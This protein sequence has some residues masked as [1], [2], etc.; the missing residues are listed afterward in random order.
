MERLILENR[1]DLAKVNSFVFQRE[2]FKTVEVSE[3]RYRKIENS[4]QVIQK[5]IADGVPVYGVT[6]GFGDSCDRYVD[7]T[8]AE[9]LQFNLIEYLSCGQG[10][11]L[12]IEAARAMFVIRLNSLSLGQSGVS[13]DL[14]KHMCLL[15]EKDIIPVVPREGSLGASGDLV[16]LAYLAQTIQGQGS[17]LFQGKTQD[18]AEVFK[19]L[20]IP[21]YKLKAKE[22]L[23]IVNGTATMAGLFLYNL[24]LAQKLVGLAE[25]A[26]AWQCLSLMG[27][28]EAFDRFIN[29]FAKTNPGQKFSANEISQLLDAENYR[30]LRGQD[31][32]AADGKTLGFVQ[33]RYSLRCV[34]Q[35]LGPIRENLEKCEEI[36]VHE[37][38]SITDNPVINFENQLEMGGNFYGGYL[39]QGMDYLK[40]N[41]AQ[42]ADLIDRQVMML[43]DDKSNR[44]LSANLVDIEN[45]PANEKFVHHGLKGIHQTVSAITSE[46][47]QKSIPSSIFSR[48]SESHNQDKVSLGMSAAVTCFEMLESLYKI[49][50]M[51]LVCLAQ[52]LDLRKIQLQGKSSLANYK[53]IRSHVSFVKADR[54]LGQA[55][56]NL[57]DELKQ[58]ALYK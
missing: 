31:I 34:P 1:L 56:Q 23:A 51:Q 25:L 11:V 3:E 9:R 22:G 15:L 2:K 8:T 37:I 27:K 43:V 32:Q 41:L 19:K 39:A 13:S 7:A 12:P 50:S 40:I 49:S 58:V 21:P 45:L 44:G 10:P 16:P 53:M 6:T 14:I 48:S 38:N 30:P 52:A 33:D 5:L 18:C 57:T 36:I 54:S 20:N 17:V 26:T 4:Y 29:E 46:V 42:L 47:M 35:I 28:R 24:K 55:I